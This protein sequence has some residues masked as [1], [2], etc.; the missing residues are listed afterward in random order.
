MLSLN[1]SLT[2]ASQALQAQDGAIG[3]VNNNIANVNTAGYSRQTVN[4]SAEALAGGVDG[5]VTFGGY[6]SVRDELLQLQIDA[7]TS[8]QSSLDAQSASLSTVQAAFS[9]TTSGIGAAMS[10]FFSS[11][12]GLSSAPSDTSLRQSVLSSASQLVNSFHQGASALV[13]AQRSADAQV[14]SVVA[15]INQLSKQIAS[16]NVQVAGNTTAGDGGGQL[17]DQ[18]DQ[19]TAQLASL[20]GIAVTRTEGQPTVTTG[21]GSA[22]VLGG[23]AFAL[24]VST[25]ADGLE[26]VTDSG[27]N[28]I[29]A[30]L[31]GGTLGG[32]LAIRDQ[33][34]PGML[35]SLNTL[36]TQFA[37]AINTA[38]ATGYDS[39]GAAGQPMFAIS[40]TDQNASAGIAVALQSASGVAAS[41][42]GSAGSS[43]NLNNLLSV[44]T[45]ALPSGDTPTNTYANLVASIGSTAANTSASLAATKLSLQQLSSQQSAISG[46][47][48]DEEST[49]LIRYQQAYTAAAHVISTVNSLFSV[50][51]NMGAN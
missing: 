46:V 43:G 25:G 49:N 15:Q 38:Q 13:T 10:T 35:D 24:Q 7:K 50:V 12:S 34:L 23:R 28:D 16:L 51:M 18:R 29:T 39:S 31:T 40:A 6:T 5:G 21:N 36:A 2:L 41:S 42:D 9:G 4:L 47:S 45:S 27:G 30:S 44:Q 11:L 19:L 33:V 14:S 48:I 17:T 3:V 20:T 22:L 32:A 26:R 8:D 37:S 1:A